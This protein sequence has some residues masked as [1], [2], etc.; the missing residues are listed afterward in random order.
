MAY[1]DKE[2][3]N[4]ASRR[5]HAENP[6]ARAEY[7]RQYRAANRD[8]I[9]ARGREPK[10]LAY[11]RAYYAENKQKLA[12]S[13]RKRYILNREKKLVQ[14]RAAYAKATAAGKRR[15]KYPLPT[16]KIPA[17]CECCSKKQ[18]RALALDHCHVTGKFRGWLCSNCNAALGLLG[19]NAIGVRSALV[20]LEK[21]G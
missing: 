8:K 4:A 2:K 6:Q 17:V 11:A 10:R 21:H 20:Y 12:A 3:R 18:K 1:K 14:S 5:R 19:D 9:N 16:R 7:Q 15:K 13:A